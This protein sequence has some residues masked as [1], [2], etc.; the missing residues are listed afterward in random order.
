MGDQGEWGGPVLRVISPIDHGG[1]M[2]VRE[3]GDN[4]YLD[5]TYGPPLQH[6]RRVLPRPWFQVSL[7]GSR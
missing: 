5:G 2:E 7:L 3:E 1:W 6:H 4:N